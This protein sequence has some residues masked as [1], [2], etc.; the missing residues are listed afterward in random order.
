MPTVIS[1]EV[2]RMAGYCMVIFLAGLQTIPKS[3]YEA[4]EMDGA[5]YLQR[6]GH[7]TLPFLRPALTVTTILNLVYG[8]T[9]FDIIFVLTRGGPGRITSVMNTAVFF[10][11]SYGRYG[12]ATALGVIIFAITLV[13]AFFTLKLLQRRETEVA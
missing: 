1:V 6:L 9:A 11:F 2:W 5:G 3:Y 12:I 8:L 13:I 4:A 10:E 7:I